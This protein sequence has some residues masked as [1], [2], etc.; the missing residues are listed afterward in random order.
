MKLLPTR[1]VNCALPVPP[2]FRAYGKI[3]PSGESA[4]HWIWVWPRL[5]GS[6]RTINWLFPRF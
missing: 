3:I 1:H 2:P 4:A 5:L 6:D